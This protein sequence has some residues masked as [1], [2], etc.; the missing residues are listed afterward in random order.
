M[1]LKYSM[2]AA[3]LVS[4]VV[5]AGSY[6]SVV[7]IRNTSS[8][9]IHQLYLSSTDSDDWGPDQLGDDVIGHRET[10]RL[11]GIPCDDYDVKLVDEDGDECVVGGVTLCADADAWVINDDDLLDCQAATDN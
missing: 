10:F 9:D 3:A 8:W 7:A 5:I 4:G 11:S 6:D 2:L 1:K